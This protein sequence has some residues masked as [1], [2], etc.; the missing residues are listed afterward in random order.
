MTVKRTGEGINIRHTRHCASRSSAN[1]DCKPTYQAQVYSSRERKPIRRTFPT[2]AQARAWRRQAQIELRSGRLNAPTK[3]LIAEAAEE[4]L[5]SARTGVVRTRSGEP[6]KPSAIRG[7]RHSLNRFV[8][9]ELGTLRVSALTRARIQQLVDQ[10]IARGYS[11]STAR[12]AVLPLRAIYRRAIQRGELVANPTLGLSMPADRARR[13]RVSPPGEIQP[14]LDAVP[15]GDRALW[16]T[17]IYGGLRRGE[18]QALRWSSIDLE[19]G[20]LSVER[21]WDPFAGEIEPKSRSGRRR[22]PIPALL[23]SHLVEHRLR[24]GA[25]GVGF[26]LSRTG[27]RPFEGSAVLKRA[28]LGFKRAALTPVSLH[29]CRHTYASLMIAAGVNT[30]ALSAY[31]GHSSVTVTLDRY[32]HLMPGNEREAASLLDAYVERVARP[33]APSAQASVT[34]LGSGELRG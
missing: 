14:L 34:Q 9:P 27:L 23:R 10:L 29:E 25:G 11:A 18:L 15:V 19:A 7:Y 28:K 3:T 4:W 22:V 30:K 33:R 8:L 32:G 12:N 6:Y 2:V 24:Q 17:A 20:I 16:A 5:E 31:M 13:D 1:C 21:S 26:A